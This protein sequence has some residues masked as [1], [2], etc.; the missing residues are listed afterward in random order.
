MSTEL[1]KLFSPEVVAALEDRMREIA[2]ESQ[3]PERKS[4]PDDELTVREVAEIC[5]VKPRTVYDWV[6]RNKRGEDGGLKHHHSPGGQLR[7]YRK[8]VVESAPR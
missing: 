8:D 3:V 6:E 1:T 2:R 7:F 4:R 5:R